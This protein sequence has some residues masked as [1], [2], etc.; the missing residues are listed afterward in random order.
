MNKTRLL[1]GLV[2]ATVTPF[3][4]SGDL[5]LA[6]VGPMVDFL[7][8]SGVSGLYVCGS[9]GEGVSLDQQE[10]KEAAAAFVKAAAGRVPVVVQVGHNSLRAAADLAAHAEAAGAAAVSA[11]CPSYFPVRTVRALTAS[12]REIAAA[13]A[14][15]PFYYYHIPALTGSDVDM[16]Q[17]L[18]EAGEQLPNLRGLKFTAP[19]AYHFQECLELDAGRFEVLWGVDEMLL[20][21]LAV[22][23]YGAVGSTYNIAAPLHRRLIAAFE[24]GDLAAARQ[25]Q[26]Q[27]LAFLRVLTS[28]PYHAALRETLALLGQPCGTSR[29]PNLG[30]SPEQRQH[31]RTALE[32]LGFFSW[33]KP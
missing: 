10:R 15:T 1:H 9:T 12:M 17:F 32:A 29:L 25:C 26:A 33:V 22:G 5:D 11:T 18:R 8:A 28:L 19:T 30:L 21:A 27:V 23:C 14:R 20:S 3:D 16:L 7:I 24:R 2:A 13:A 6:R 31:L 4:E